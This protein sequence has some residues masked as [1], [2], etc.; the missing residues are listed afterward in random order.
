MAAIISLTTD[1]GLA[2]Y[3]VGSIKGAIYGQLPEANIVDITHEIKKFDIGH[4]AF[5]LKNIIRDFPNGTVHIIGVLPDATTETPHVAV[6]YD[7]QFFI[8]TDNGMF[9]LFMER[10][11]S[12]IIELTNINQETD[13]RTFPTKD[14]FVHAACHLA[15]GGTIE[16][17]GNI[18]EQ[19]I[20]RSAFNPVIDGEMIRGNVQ[21]I[22][23]YGN[24]ITNIS[25]SLFNEVRKDRRFTIFFRNDKYK[26]NKISENYNDVQES[27]VIA[28]FGATR[29][30]EIAIRGG[31][32]SSLLGLNLNEIIR[33]EVE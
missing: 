13:I 9:S 1:L 16:V 22:D 32:A 2:D 18:R 15:R 26:I 14:V 12:K 24:I 6:E 28:L 10:P 25:E 31:N 17:L 3:Y 11:P 7:G 33:V 20:Q 29:N 8:G 27:E 19:L 30:L 23:S 5:V 4:A 21:Y